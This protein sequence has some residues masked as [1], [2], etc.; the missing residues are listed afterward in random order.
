MLDS[1]DAKPTVLV[2]DDE[3]QICLLVQRALVRFSFRTL[4]AS[5][6]AEAVD[7]VAQNA[8]IAAV[9]S[10][11]RMPGGTG[12]DL[13]SH[14]KKQRPDLPVVLM[15]GFAEKDQYREA[16]QLGAFEYLIKPFEICDLVKTVSN[17]VAA[18]VRLV[19]KRAMPPS[20]A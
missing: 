9:L 6:L 17:A 10:D 12:I 7:L 3:Q 14:L 13:L 15:T 11:I 5:R 19:A 8:D 1:G 4:L 18:H 16:M 2:V 20:P